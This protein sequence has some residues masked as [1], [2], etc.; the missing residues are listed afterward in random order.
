MVVR[1]AAEC[2]ELERELLGIDRRVE[3]AGLLRLADLARQERQELAHVLGDRRAHGAV[4][5]AVE[6]G[7]DGVEEAAAAEHL[8]AEVLQPAIRIACSRA[9]PRGRPRGPDHV[10]DEAAAGGV[11]RRQLQLLLGAEVRE[12]TALA[13]AQLGREPADGQALEP[14]DG[15]DVGRRLQDRLARGV[16]APAAPVGL[17]GN[18][19]RG[20]GE[21]FEVFR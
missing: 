12:Q 3:V 21:R 13:H 1:G 9:R 11:D 19:G 20:A 6:L 4:R 5:P 16:A 18:G 10:V 7:L 14:F 17:V 15:G 8:R 2:V